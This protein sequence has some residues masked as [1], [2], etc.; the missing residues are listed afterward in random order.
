MAS[1]PRTT[2]PAH[3]TGAVEFVRLA[4]I[5]DDDAFR[6][7]DEGDV[8]DLATSIGRLGQLV[9]IELRL[10]PGAGDDGPRW[11][12]VSGFRRLSALRML[13][14]EE[15]LARVHGDLPDEDAWALAASQALLTEP[16]GAVEL[17]TARERLRAAGAADWADDLVDDAQVRAPVAPELRERFHA[18]LRGEPDPEA[19]AA[20]PDGTVEM[21]PEEIVD[22]LL[23]RLYEINVDL[24]AAWEAW[25]DLAPEGKRQIV[26]QARYIYDLFP[27]L[28]SSSE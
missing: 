13:H 21:T 25:A 6:L 8:S 2:A 14:R 10:R 20:A 11:Q 12:V 5:A 18:F 15:A 16:L 3:A 24:A 23:R 19:A 27:F 9:P 17:E 28:E 22:D 1:E 26:E 7:R 4:D